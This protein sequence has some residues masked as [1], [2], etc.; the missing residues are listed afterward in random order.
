MPSR[1]SVHYLFTSVGLSGASREL[2]SS[3]GPATDAQTVLRDSAGRVERIATH[4]ERPVEGLAG[5]GGAEDEDAGLVRVLVD[6]DEVGAGSKGG[7]E[8][9]NLQLAQAVPAR[10][11]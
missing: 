2:H 9:G 4:V 5:E 1:P 3:P 10:L 8:A 7:V 6:G 11:E